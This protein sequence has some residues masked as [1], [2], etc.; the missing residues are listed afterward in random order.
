MTDRQKELIEFYIPSP[1]DPTLLFGEYYLM[2]NGRSREYIRKVRVGSIYP[3]SE[4]YSS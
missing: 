4:G 3:H 1:K 2:Y